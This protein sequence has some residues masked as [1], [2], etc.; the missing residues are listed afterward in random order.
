VDKVQHWDSR[1][2]FFAAAAEAMRR[3]LVNRA[4][5]KRCL[6]RGGGWKRIDLDGWPSWRTPRT[7]TSS[8]STR[9]WVGWPR[10]VRL[11]PKSKHG[12]AVALERGALS[13]RKR[14]RDTVFLLTAVG[15]DGVLWIIP[16][17]L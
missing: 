13:A 2:H 12:A 11:A 14:E 9:P 1:G 6:K 5:E 7:R 16:I 17:D 10:R 8:P 4:H 3:I 15:L